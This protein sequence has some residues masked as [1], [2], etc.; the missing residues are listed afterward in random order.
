MISNRQIVDR[1]QSLMN[2]EMRISGFI[3]EY[4]GLLCPAGACRDGGINNLC[5][6][7]WIQTNSTLGG[8]YILNA[9][10]GGEI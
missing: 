2:P 5:R 6:I 7:I 3:E 8:S 1:F 9:Y 10:G 4:S